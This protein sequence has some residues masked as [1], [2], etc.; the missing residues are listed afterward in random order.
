MKNPFKIWFPT[1]FGLILDLAVLASFAQGGGQ[2][3][4]KPPGKAGSGSKAA[5][6]KARRAQRAAA[7]RG[8]QNR[9]AQSR[10]GQTKAGQ[11]KQPEGERETETG[12]GAAGEKEQRDP[13][14]DSASRAQAPQG[15]DRGASQSP[16][17]DTSPDGSKPMRRRQM[18]QIRLPLR[19]A[20]GPGAA[21]GGGGRSGGQAAVPAA[22]QQRLRQE[23]LR[24]IGLTPDQQARM[25]SVRQNHDDEL[26]ASGR[27]VRQARRALNQAIMAEH[28]DE[29]EVDRLAEDLG[30][31]QKAQIKLN[32]K[33]R[34]EQRLVLTPEQLTRLKLIEQ[35]VQRTRQQQQRLDLQMQEPD[36]SARPPGSADPEKD[37]EVDPLE[38]LFDPKDFA[39]VDQPV[40]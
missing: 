20:A 34:A 9:A 25:Q 6:V 17:Q 14:T 1:I 13:A 19:G 24:Q 16:S 11:G 2:R 33:I 29:A 38:M 32:A 39:D 26:I 18:G 4:A 22:N 10:A 40:I 7:I 21:Q 3:Q 30:N 37:D 36:S 27:R 8:A 31:A 35:Q 15:A 23:I 12:K 5:Q 28:F